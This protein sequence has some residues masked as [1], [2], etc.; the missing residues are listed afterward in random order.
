[1]LAAAARALDKCTR[2][3]Y[4][5]N[6]EKTVCS[7]ECRPVH[8]LAHALKGQSEHYSSDLLCGRSLSRTSAKNAPCPALPAHGRAITC[9]GASPAVQPEDQP[10]PEGVLAAVPVGFVQR[11]HDP[12]LPRVRHE[13]GRRQNSVPKALG[14]LGTCRNHA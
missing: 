14:A 8:L 4:G 7:A 2:G 5:G 12:H 1:M 10:S 6:S 3:F 9:L 11:L 13:R